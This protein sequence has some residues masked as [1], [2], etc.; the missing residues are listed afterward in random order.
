MPRAGFA[1]RHLAAGLAALVTFAAHAGA[2]DRTAG[3]VLSFL[4]TT[5]GVAT[6][7]FTKDQQAAEA[8]RETITRALLVELTTTPLTT[9]SSGFSYRFNS[10]LGTM[11]RVTRGF[12]PLY[13]DRAITAGR[14]QATFSVNYSYSQFASLDGRDLRNGS[15]VTT[16]NKF[17]DES[18]PFDVE[19]LQL[20][21][22]SS[23]VTFLGNYGV[24]DWLD[25][26]VAVP[27]VQLTISGQRVNTYRGTSLI[28]ARGIAESAGL[29]DIPVR[30]KLQ[31]T[32]SGSS[33]LA[34]D[35]EVRLPTGDPDELRGSGRYRVQGSLI[36]SAGAGILEGHVSAGAAAGGV[37][38]ELGFGGALD[39]AVTDRVT[40]SAE[41]LVRRLNEL[42]GIQEVSAPHP[43]L[44]GVDTI[45][46]L[47]EAGANTTITSVA[48]VRWNIGNT[49]LLNTYVL[50]PI[51]SS[52]LKAK[53]SPVV[54]LDYS[55]VR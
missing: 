23:T 34:A 47:P 30:A 27:F 33:G 32:R 39:A 43:L 8:T 49:W 46:L 19:A 50:V 42:H 45:R 55:F 18:T 36:A 2:Q 10:S 16:S 31:L 15:L 13:V 29:A 6:A 25:V 41:V 44:S 24:T 22:E 54:S 5:Q 17:R 12:G 35:V 48:G 7:D 9:S 14:G 53:F 20:D 28:Q 37:S 21:M 38:E 26:G 51:K 1:L 52:G 3:D 4:I 40:F 11:E